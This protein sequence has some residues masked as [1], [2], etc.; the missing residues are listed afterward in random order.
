MA[1][2]DLAQV[3]RLL[4]TTRAVRKRLD[5]DRPVEPEVIT[6]CLRL[7]TY[8]PSAANTQK[9]RWLVVTDAD[10]RQQIADVYRGLFYRDRSP[11]E[12]DEMIEQTS[13]SDPSTARLLS[14]AKHLA[15]NFHRIPVHVV[16]CYLERPNI[17]GG[18]VE[19]ATMYGSVIQAVWS[20]QLALRSRG[21]GSVWTTMHLHTEQVVAD[22]LGIPDDVTQVALIPVAYT[23]GEDFRPPPRQPVEKVTYWNSWPAD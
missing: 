10:K 23:I 19:L 9:W 8:T 5:L 17:E 11:A 6:E 3:D 16:A 15:D 20:F 1:N 21:L 14:A 22:I 13:T 12:Y 2:F 18:N 4:S 7:A